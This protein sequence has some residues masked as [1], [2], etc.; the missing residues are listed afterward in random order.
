MGVLGGQRGPQGVSAEV[1]RQLLPGGVGE[2]GWAGLQRGVLLAEDSEEGAEA[3]LS[4]GRDMQTPLGC[5]P[6]AEGA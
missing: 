3:P 5:S 1:R 6:W 2:H 4:R